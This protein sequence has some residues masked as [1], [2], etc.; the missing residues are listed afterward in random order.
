MFT[1]VIQLFERD[2]RHFYAEC[3]EKVTMI[4]TWGT[5][6]SCRRLTDGQTYRGI[7]DNQ[8]NSQNVTVTVFWLYQNLHTQLVI[9]KY[10]RP[11][12]LEEYMY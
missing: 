8:R 2:N 5:V 3:W 1:K 9:Y 6:T 11:H 12:T 7:L 10:T 4:A